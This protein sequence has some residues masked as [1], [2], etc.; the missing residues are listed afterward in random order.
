MPWRCGN[1]RELGL[2]KYLCKL[3]EVAE[4]DA[5]TGPSDSCPPREIKSLPGV[6]K[7][8]MWREV[9]VNAASTWGLGR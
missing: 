7:V 5:D 4:S 9:Q 3:A 2:A 8:G 6:G 1:R